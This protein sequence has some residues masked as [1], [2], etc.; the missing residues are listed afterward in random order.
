MQYIIYVQKKKLKSVI[1]LFEHLKIGESALSVNP[2]ILFKAVFGSD[3]YFL[4]LSQLRKIRHG[5][6]KTG[7]ERGIRKT[8][9]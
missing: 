6:E 3:L 2:G 4:R 5:E 9:V 7:V 8:S 1:I